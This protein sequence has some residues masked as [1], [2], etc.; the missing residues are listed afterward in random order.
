MRRLADV[1]PGERARELA[2]QTG[3]DPALVELILGGVAVDPA[4]G[5]RGADRR[6]ERR[7]D[8]RQR[9]HR[10]LEPAG[11]R[12]AWC[13][14]LPVDADASARRIRAEIRRSR[15]HRAR[16][17]DRRQ[18]RAPVAARP[19]R[20]RDRLRRDRARSTTGGGA[21]TASGRELA[22]TA[23]AV[24]DQAASAADLVRDK[25]SGVP[26]AVISGLD[27]LVTPRG[28]PR[29]QGPAAA[30][31][32]KTS[33]ASRALEQLLLRASGAAVP[34]TGTPGARSLARGP[35]DRRAP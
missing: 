25:D 13:A 17:R 19:G 3:K 24:A 18:L 23:I 27:H 32:T 29:R 15:R 22:A 9:R 16:R 14:L 8:L 7:L 12:R 28:R 1:E 6:D 26:G 21:A 4:R 34:S 35:A 5:A 2:E 20:R 30:A 33:S 31:R 11:R 10:L